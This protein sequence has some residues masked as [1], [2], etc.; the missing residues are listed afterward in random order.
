MAKVDIPGGPVPSMNPLAAFF[1]AV[2]GQRQREA[3][4]N[5]DR[6]ASV[7][8]NT[9]TPFTRLLEGIGEQAETAET[10]ELPPSEE[11]VRELLDDVHIAG[12]NLKNRPFPEEIMAYKRAVRNFLHHVVEYGYRVEQREGVPN[13]QKPGY[14]GSF[15]D[16]DFK[17]RKLHTQVLVVDRKLEQ[18]A[19]GILSGQTTQLE[20]LAHIEEI[21]GILID[22]LQ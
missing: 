3:K 4:K 2:Q 6:A 22:L 1:P 10:R 7:R 19:A 14:K 5:G 12:D 20:L 8:S 11:A 21:T 9:K 15:E 16:P 13:Y 17:K 18:L